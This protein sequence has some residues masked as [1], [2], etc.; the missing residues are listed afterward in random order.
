MLIENIFALSLFAFMFMVLVVYVGIKKG[1]F[2]GKPNQSIAVALLFCLS[3]MAFL[4]SGLAWIARV[5]G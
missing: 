5:W 3:L 1:V 4:I 2:Y